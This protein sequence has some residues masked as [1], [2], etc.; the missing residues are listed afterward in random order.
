MLVER[1]QEEKI[2]SVA[3][4]ASEFKRPRDD[5]ASWRSRLLECH[6]T[7]DELRAL[8]AV[9]LTFSWQLAGLFMLA[10]SVLCLPAQILLYIWTQEKVAISAAVSVAGVFA[11]LPILHFLPIPRRGMRAQGKRDLSPPPRYS[12]WDGSK[13]N[14]LSGPAPLPPAAAISTVR[15]KSK[16]SY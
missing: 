8:V 2:R 16:T 10:I 15:S 11:M 3:L 9:P 12:R 6:C 7:Y 5:I 4:P 14:L 13:T 1:L